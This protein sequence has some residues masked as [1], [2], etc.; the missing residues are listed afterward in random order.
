MQRI[1]GSDN[2]CYKVTRNVRHVRTY[3]VLRHANV[4]WVLDVAP[5]HARDSQGNTREDSFQLHVN[6][7][8]CVC[9]REC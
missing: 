9:D 2:T 8:M 6:E 7:K 4:C 3:Q 5:T 1:L